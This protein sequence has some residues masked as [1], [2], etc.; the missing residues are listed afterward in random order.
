MFRVILRALNHAKTHH[1]LVNDFANIH[2][3]LRVFP[4]VPL[5]LEYEALS[6][7]STQIWQQSTH[8]HMKY[9]ICL[10]DHEETTGWGLSIYLTW[11][12]LVL[13]IAIVLR[14][15]INS[16]YGDG[17]VHQKHFADQFPFSRPEK[18]YTVH[19]QT[20]TLRLNSNKLLLIVEN[21]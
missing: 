17:L 19:W 20:Q 3:C 18:S 1:F 15:V 9:N 11:M 14:F 6:A 4:H 5:L 7:F 8:S 13:H 2:S 21:N 16:T 12:S 10:R